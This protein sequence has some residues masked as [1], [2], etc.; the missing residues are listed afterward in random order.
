MGSDEGSITFVDLI[1]KFGFSGP[2][3]V[4]RVIPTS[5]RRKAKN[6]VERLLTPVLIL[7]YGLAS[8]PLKRVTTSL[9]V[10]TRFS[11]SMGHSQYRNQ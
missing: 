6:D 7:S 1:S 11:G 5:T 8:N 9:L 4:M 2:I 3:M 10:V